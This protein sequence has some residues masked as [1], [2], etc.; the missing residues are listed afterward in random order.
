VLVSATNGKTTTTRLI[1]EALRAVGQVASN[2]LG[3]NMPA[4]ITAAM[5]QDRDAQYAVIEVDE[6]YL[7][8]W[9]ARRSEG[10]RAAEPLA[11][12]A[13]PG[14]R[15][16][17][18]G[19]ALADGLAGTSATVVA[20]ADDPLVV[21]AAGLARAWCGSRRAGV[22]GRRLVL[23]AVRRGAQAAGT[24]LDVRV[25]RLPAPDADVAAGGRGAA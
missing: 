5:A 11:R 8:A 13:G 10:D 24:G 22:A 12:P 18:D 6:K 3:A 16:P 19:A 23:S 7:P 2:A 14:R 1:A 25:L 9:P 17:D 21:W 20:N 4:G 15:D